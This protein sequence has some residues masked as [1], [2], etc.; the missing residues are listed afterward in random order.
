MFFG[1]KLTGNVKVSGMID[2]ESVGVL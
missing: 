1:K 2:P